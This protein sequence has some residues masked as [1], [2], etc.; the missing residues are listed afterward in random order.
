MVDLRWFLTGRAAETRRL[1]LMGILRATVITKLWAFV[2]LQRGIQN[3]FDKNDQGVIQ[4]NV[5]AT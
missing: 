4:E 5:R 2:C 1:L 3:A